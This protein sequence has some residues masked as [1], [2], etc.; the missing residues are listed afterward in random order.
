MTGIGRGVGMRGTGLPLNHTHTTIR[1][2]VPDRERGI[3]D[4]TSIRELHTVEVK[5]ALPFPTTDITT[6]LNITP[7]AIITGS[8][9]RDPNLR[10]IEQTIATLITRDREGV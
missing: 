8:L 5:V 6:T 4:I 7:I 3:V 2:P 1:D 10:I 9:A